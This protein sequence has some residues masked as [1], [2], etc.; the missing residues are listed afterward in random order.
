MYMV[1]YGQ[2]ICVHAQLQFLHEVKIVQK[3]DEDDQHEHVHEILLFHVRSMKIV[4]RQELERV[5]LHDENEDD[6]ELAD[7]E[8]ED[9]LE[10][11][12]DENEDHEREHDIVL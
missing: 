2:I 1:K 10:L 5:S 7:D 12:D 9:D 11:V 6:L 8:N 3:R 4:T